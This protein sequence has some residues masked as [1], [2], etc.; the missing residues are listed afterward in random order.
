M[1]TKEVKASRAL[2]ALI[3]ERINATIQMGATDAG[4]PD[5]SQLDIGRGVWVVPV[6][7]AEP[8]K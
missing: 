3:N 6:L 4:L 8:D 5:G 1:P 2:L 7:E